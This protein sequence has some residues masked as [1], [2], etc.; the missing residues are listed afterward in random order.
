MN[1]R[2]QLLMKAREAGRTGRPCPV[3]RGDVSAE[4]LALF[5]A[6][7]MAKVS[8]ETGADILPDHAESEHPDLQICRPKNQ[9]TL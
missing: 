5:H 6:W 2:T 3:E 4:G 9:E 1:T 7:H 8:R